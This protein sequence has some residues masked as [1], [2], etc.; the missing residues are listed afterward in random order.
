MIVDSNNDTIVKAVLVV[1][2]VLV[3]VI[4][5]SGISRIVVWQRVVHFQQKDIV[6][7]LMFNWI[8]HARHR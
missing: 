6:Q 8:M 1:A 7:L 3:I 5:R 4:N 2:I